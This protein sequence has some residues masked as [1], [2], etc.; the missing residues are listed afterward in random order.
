[1]CVLV[2]PWICKIVKLRLNITL[3]NLQPNLQYFRY[4]V[5]F[6]SISSYLLK[7]LCNIHTEKLILCYLLMGPFSINIIIDKVINN[8][9]SVIVSYHPA[10]YEGSNCYM[11]ICNIRQT[12]AGQKCHCDRT[13]REA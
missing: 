13:R 11:L 6:Y 3:Q 8:I 12:D 7:I 10:L 1:M 4:F 2:A 5:Y 9:L